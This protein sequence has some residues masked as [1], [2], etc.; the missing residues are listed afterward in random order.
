VVKRNEIELVEEWL[1]VFVDRG[2]RPALKEAG[3]ALPGTIIFDQSFPSQG[4]RKPG[5]GEWWEG[6]ASTNGVPRMIIPC[7]TVDVE[8]ITDDVMY[9]AIF[10]AVGVKDGRGRA[11]NNC[12]RRI[13]MD[14]PLPKCIPGPRLRER[15]NEVIADMPPFPRGA[16]NFDKFKPSGEERNVAGR[17]APQRG[18]MMKAEC[19]QCSDEGREY[20]VRMSAE[21]LRDPGPPLCPVHNIPLWHQELPPEARE[22]QAVRTTPVTDPEPELIER[23]PVALIEYQPGDD[24]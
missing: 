2:V 8:S 15:L 20:I 1:S 22:K 13:G 6:S 5:R 12:A 3:Y 11:F 19:L 9:L 7:G 16:L 24:Q 14:G 4:K 10:G 18:R 21:K 17:A 23:Q